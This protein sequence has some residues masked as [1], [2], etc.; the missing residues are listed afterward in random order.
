MDVH[1]QNIEADVG[2]TNILCGVSGFC[3]PGEI[4]AIMGHSGEFLKSVFY[5][6]ML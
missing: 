4:L 2:D 6:I 1:F 5:F 3:Q